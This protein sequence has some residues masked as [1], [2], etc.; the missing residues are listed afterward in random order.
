MAII[1]LLGTLF[2][3]WNRFGILTT[4][5]QLFMVANWHLHKYTNFTRLATLSLVTPEG[6]RVI[7]GTL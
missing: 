6:A 3:A 1:A 5:Y 2:F 7:I 4:L